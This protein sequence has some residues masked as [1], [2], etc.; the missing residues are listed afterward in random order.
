MYNKNIYMIGPCQN[1]FTYDPELD[2]SNNVIVVIGTFNKYH[3]YTELKRYKN[4]VHITPFRHTHIA[5]PLAYMVIPSFWVS[6]DLQE[7][8]TLYKQ[9]GYGIFNDNN[10]SNAIEFNKIHKNVSFYPKD[11]YLQLLSLGYSKGRRRPTTGMTSL[12]YILNCNPKSVNMYGVS[13]WTDVYSDTYHIERKGL[14]LPQSG[15]RHDVKLEQVVFKS[16]YNQTKIPIYIHNTHLKEFV[17][18]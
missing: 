8:R 14:H 5:Y 4:L 12:W 6:Q 9:Y 16:I 2:T 17:M 10:T 3:N 18:T 7:L 1:T 11:V 13:F 15:S